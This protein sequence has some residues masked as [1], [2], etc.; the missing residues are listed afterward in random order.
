MDDIYLNI[1]ICLDYD[2]IYRCMQVCR[3]YYGVIC[4]EIFWMNVYNSRYLKYSL[5]GG[6]YETCKF[7]NQLKVLINDMGVL[8]NYYK[9]Y[10]NNYNK[11]LERQELSFAFNKAIKIPKNI[12]LLTNLVNLYLHNNKIETIKSEIFMLK[13]LKILNLSN[14]N[15]NILPTEICFLEELVRISICNNKLAIIPTE[16]GLLKNLKYLSASR[17]MIKTIPTEIGNLEFLNQLYLYGNIIDMIPREFSKLNMLGELYVD[18]I[19]LPIE[20]K[21]VKGLTIKSIYGFKVDNFY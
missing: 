6:Y 17:N 10:E 5:K 16:I 3:N 12:G 19:L 8:N 11:L 14:N 20:L 1:F 9:H 13:K 4:K 15:I 7:Y 18:D 2:D 21:N